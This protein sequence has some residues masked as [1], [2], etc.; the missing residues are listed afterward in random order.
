LAELVQ[1]AF[2]SIGSDSSWI[3]GIEDP[4]E[5]NIDDVAVAVTASAIDQMR[6]NPA[7]SDR[8]RQVHSNLFHN[9]QER[10]KVIESSGLERQIYSID[11]LSNNNTHNVSVEHDTDQEHSHEDAGDDQRVLDN[12][13]LYSGTLGV[14]DIIGMHGTDYLN[15][16]I[17]RYNSQNPDAAINYHPFRFRSFSEGASMQFRDELRYENLEL[18]RTAYNLAS[19]AAG[20]VMTHCQHGRHRAR[21]VWIVVSMVNN[22]PAFEFLENYR[23]IPHLSEIDAEEKQE[24][25]DYIVTTMGSIGMPASELNY[26]MDDGVGDM[27]GQL[28]DIAL[29]EDYRNQIQRN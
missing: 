9:L 17:D 3:D 15:P 22:P 1:S 12:L 28:G 4:D 8:A 20:N 14:T 7:T 2:D 27:I 19:N 18:F 13:S 16:L 25:I 29:D 26:Y 21:F 23:G 5:H 6:Y 11:C 10:F 24:V